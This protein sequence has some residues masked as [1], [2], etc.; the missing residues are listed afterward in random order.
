MKNLKT[1]I[2]ILLQITVITNTISMGTELKEKDH[3]EERNWKYLEIK[4]GISRFKNKMTEK[5]NATVYR[6]N[7]T[8]TKWDLCQVCKA[9]STFKNQLISLINRLKKKN[10]MTI[11]ADAE[12]A[13]HKIQQSLSS[14]S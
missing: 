11:S 13:F 12:K 1:A 8:M 14:A 7:Y 2:T 4:N 3:D 10:Y 9:S 5:K 6:K